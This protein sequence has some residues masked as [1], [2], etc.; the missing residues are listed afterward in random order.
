[1]KTKHPALHWPEWAW[2]YTTESLVGPAVLSAQHPRI[3]TAQDALRWMD[4]Q[5]YDVRS[6]TS[7]GWED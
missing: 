2:Y 6:A 4:Q 3:A 5:G 7:V 1:M